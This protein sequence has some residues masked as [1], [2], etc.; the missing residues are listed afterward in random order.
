MLDK[1]L[2]F[3]GCHKQKSV[4]EGESSVMLGAEENVEM[5]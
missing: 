2:L 5:G 1:N 4:G 3:D